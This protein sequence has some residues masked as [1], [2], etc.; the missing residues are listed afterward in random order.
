M[1]MMMIMIVLW[2]CVAGWTGISSGWIRYDENDDGDDDGDCPVVTC[3]YAGDV[4][5]MTIVLWSRVT[6]LLM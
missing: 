6:M 5:T 4:T 3:N 1:M 2:S